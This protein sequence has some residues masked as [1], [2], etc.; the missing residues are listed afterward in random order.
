MRYSEMR[1][2]V[3]SSQKA[4]LY[5]YQA[6]VLKAVME[7]RNVILQAPT[8]AGK[9]LAA[10]Y[11]FF[12]NLSRV[13]ARHTL[14][15]GSP[16]PLTCRYAVPMRVLATQFQQEY[17]DYF[18]KIDRQGGTRM[19]ETYDKL[20][21]T[22]PAIQ[23]GESPD[24]PQFE[25]PLT[26]CTIDQ[27]L[28]S[29]LG[30]PFSLNTGRAN[31]NVGAVAGSY[32]I[33]DEFHLY[34]A[35]DTLEG[36][37]L[38]ALEML[39]LLKGVSPFILMTAT[40]STQLLTQLGI[41][42]DAEVIRVGD[43]GS[44]ESVADLERIFQGRSRTLRVSPEPMTADSVLETHERACARQ[45]CATLVV[46][47]TVTRAQD[48]YTSLRDALNK[49]N[50]RERIQLEL[51]HSRFTAVDRGAKSQRLSEL[52]G[53][54]AWDQ[55]GQFT[56]NEC[57]VIATQVVEVG[58]NISAG[59]LHTELA[60]ASSVIQRM[61]RC[62]RFAH[63]QGEVIVYPIPDS[64]SPAVPAT[65]DSASDKAAAQ[66]GRAAAARYLPYDAKEC[67]ATW[68]ALWEM[69]GADA[70]PFD[71]A[72]EQAL[73]DAVH[74]EGDQRMLEHFSQYKTSLKGRILTALT[75]HD[76]SDT[77]TL[78]RDARSVQVVI[79]D[80]P[81]SAIVEN[82]FQ[83][84]SFSLHPDTLRGA[85]ARLQAVQAERDLPWVM[86][87]PIAIDVAGL[88]EVSGASEEDS[89]AVQRYTWQPIGAGAEVAG[90][91]LIALHPG[92]ATYDSELGFRLLLGPAIPNT[93]SP[94]WI[95]YPIKADKRR[96]PP[97]LKRSQRTYLEHI[98]GLKRAYDWSVFEELAWVGAR[99][100]DQLAAPTGSV[101]QAVR[102]A[103]ALHD[104]GKL[105][106]DWQ[107]FAHE[108][109]QAAHQSTND[110][111]FDV[112]PQTF[113]AKTDELDT[114]KDERAL[115]S[116]LT[117][118]RPP[119]HAVAGA[120]AS[121]D[122]I[123]SHVRRMYPARDLTTTEEETAYVLIRAI[124]SAIARHHAPTAT[125]YDAS[126][127]APEA[128]ATIAEG[129]RACGLDGDDLAGLDLSARQAGDAPEQYLVKPGEA[130]IPE[131]WLAFTIVRALRLCD[132]RAE[133]DL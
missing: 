69:A 132:Q 4:G 120:L 31:I 7:G 114:W 15:S 11:P 100:E 33:L 22:I 39:A 13:G 75:T 61:G 78:I 74:R 14:A 93:V 125:A 84:Q 127:W 123:G 5:A 47:N 96:S 30:V 128:S 68:S 112:A 48:M 34:P 122:L 59:A 37:R 72:K 60:P 24:D 35:S 94:R 67:Q 90:A 71:T 43:D 124:F 57:I 115:R 110:A 18:A 83:W 129:L 126:C 19:V 103:I 97:R 1:A 40:F 89:R 49:R 107:R 109:Q 92:V 53:A 63:Q 3:T 64:A 86:K 118:R 82:I 111:R 65:D 41:L 95:S 6:R 104:A 44:P 8:G 91:L 21:L 36:A 27:L 99:L 58:L 73:I 23:T 116:A 66:S 2:T 131:V 85:F 56:G 17:H 106:H 16:L 29:F 81:D 117:H 105:A 32:L 130:A 28:A 119:K 54:E 10:L 98:Q 9:T 26:F 133:R 62:A 102:L 121:A 42:L 46:C 80:D 25:S 52:M 79:H 12:Q 108:Y 55:Q 88:P 50:L 51:L 45:P 87:E 20:G 76:R 38:T 113:L 101:D 77:A 70:T